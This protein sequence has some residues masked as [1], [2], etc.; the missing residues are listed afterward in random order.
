M[1]IR[2]SSAGFLFLVGNEAV[3]G[4]GI[5]NV[6]EDGRVT[7]AHAVHGG[8][9]ALGVWP[10]AEVKSADSVR[11]DFLIERGQILDETGRRFW[12]PRALDGD[13]ALIGHRVVSSFFQPRRV[14]KPSPD[15]V[16]PDQQERNSPECAKIPDLVGRAAT[17]A[18]EAQDACLPENEKTGP[19]KREG[20]RE[21]VAGMKDDLGGGLSCPENRLAGEELRLN[22]GVRSL[23]DLLHHRNNKRVFGRETRRL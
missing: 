2:V 16:L 1:L 13:D 10:D 7:E 12:S 4:V 3:N 6:D 9:A 22:G 19:E 15:H 17:E 11:A 14:E 8:S 21:G 23:I 20:N 18:C 5:F